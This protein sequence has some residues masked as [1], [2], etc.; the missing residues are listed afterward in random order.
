M[1][2][3]DLLKLSTERGASDAQ[4]KE[5]RRGLAVVGIAARVVVQ[6]HDGRHQAFD[7]RG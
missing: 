4:A 7:L 3:N 5:A 6:R 1:H 2:I